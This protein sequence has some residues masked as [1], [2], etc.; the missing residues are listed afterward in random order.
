MMNRL[1]LSGSRLLRS[2]QSDP[3]PLPSTTSS[4]S[5]SS[6]SSISSLVDLRLSNPLSVSEMSPSSSSAE[7]SR[8]M[9]TKERCNRVHSNIALRDFEEPY[10]T[11]PCMLCH[12]YINNTPDGYFQ[13]EDCRICFHPHCYSHITNHQSYFPSYCRHKTAPVVA[14]RPLVDIG[15][16]VV[17]EDE[18]SPE[19]SAAFASIFDRFVDCEQFRILRGDIYGPRAPRSDCLVFWSENPDAGGISGDMIR[20]FRRYPELEES[21]RSYIRDE[22]CNA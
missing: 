4:P 3:S 18:D 22:W 20:L 16:Y 19:D 2:D 11:S 13:C 14:S 10:M 1:S 8:H 15:V 5:T 7:I 21:W 9:I 12:S 6:P 17:I